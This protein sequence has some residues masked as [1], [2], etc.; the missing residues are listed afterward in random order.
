MQTF[1]SKLQ[2]KKRERKDLIFHFGIQK[3]RGSR[4]K[5]SLR[6]NMAN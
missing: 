5:Q 6:K 4:C 2:L 3:R 1:S